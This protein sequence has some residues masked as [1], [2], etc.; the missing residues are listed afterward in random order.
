METML[1][2]YR[3]MEMFSRC[4]GVLLGNFSELAE[5]QQLPTLYRLVQ[6]IIDDPALPIAVTT[7]LGHQPEAHCLAYEGIRLEG[8]QL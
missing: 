1:H 7:E 3:Q 2:Q 5:K 4:N 8:S 6:D